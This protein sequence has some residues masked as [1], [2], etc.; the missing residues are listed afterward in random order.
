VSPA[1]S[2]SVSPPAPPQ[3]G[4]AIWRLLPAAPAVAPLGSQVSVWTGSQMLIRGVIGSQNGPPRAVLLSY[5]PSSAAWRTL[6]PG[7]APRTVEGWDNAVWTGTEMLVF[8]P[9]GTGAYNPVNEY[10]HAPDAG[11]TCR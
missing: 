3:A 10:T 9:D 8:G 5:T 6:A 1:V 7:P 2:A 11:I 4:A